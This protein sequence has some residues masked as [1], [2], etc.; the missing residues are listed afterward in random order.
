MSNIFGARAGFGMD[1][2]HVFLQ[3]VLTVIP[4][5]GGVVAV[6]VSRDCAGCEAG[7]PLCFMAISVP[8]TCVAW[9]LLR[10]C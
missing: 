7:L 3:N 8:V 9:C 6:V 4:L 2:S 1:A 10:N 5:I